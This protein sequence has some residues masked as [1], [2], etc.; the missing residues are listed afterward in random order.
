VSETRPVQ[1]VVAYDLSPGG[2]AALERAIEIV[3][4][5]PHHVLHIVTVLDSH[6]GVHKVTYESTDAMHATIRDFVSAA[7]ADRGS[8]RARDRGLSIQ[9]FVHCRIGKPATEILEVAEDVGADL[10]LVGSHERH[11]LLASTSERVVRDAKCPVMVI[12]PKGYKT[13][14]LEKVVEYDHPVAEYH[15]PHRYSYVETRTL[16]RPAD[17]PLV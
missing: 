8:S 4:R 14:E 11:G 12:K 17:W 9:Y 15:P 5:A 6:R 16:T 2:Y 13:V 7:F 1:V 10:V 3:V